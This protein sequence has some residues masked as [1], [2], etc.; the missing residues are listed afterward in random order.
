MATAKQPKNFAIEMCKIFGFDPSTTKSI[1]I[2]I[3]PDDLVIVETETILMQQQANEIVTE[4][5]TYQFKAYA[6]N[7]K[8]T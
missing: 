8:T 5:N 3:I 6:K 2:K 4:M 1:T 7:N